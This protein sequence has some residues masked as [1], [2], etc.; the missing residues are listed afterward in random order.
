MVVILRVESKCSKLF[1]FDKVDIYSVE[2][3]ADKMSVDNYPVYYLENDVDL[4][5]PISAP[6]HVEKQLLKV[7]YVI[8]VNNH[9]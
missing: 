1:L 7:H 6:H 9:C 2:D 4:V 8:E 5:D 3:T